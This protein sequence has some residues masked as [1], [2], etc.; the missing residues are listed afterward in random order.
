MDV[1]LHCWRVA[2][3]C[4]YTVCARPINDA[5]DTLSRRSSIRSHFG[6][7]CWMR[8]R[9][10]LSSWAGSLRCSGNLI[11]E[12]FCY[13][14]SRPL[15]TVIYKYVAVIFILWM[16]DFRP[17]Y[18]DVHV[19]SQSVTLTWFSTSMFHFVLLLRQHGAVV[20]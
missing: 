8:V 14:I 10:E 12:S 20:M 18:A 16:C 1:L 3:A 11:Y 9:H 13:N 17:K 15:I 19:V 5:P 7:P 2:N 6:K 4:V